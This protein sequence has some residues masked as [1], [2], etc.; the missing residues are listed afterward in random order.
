VREKRIRYEQTGETLTFRLPAEYGRYWMQPTAVL[1]LM[2][3]VTRA[4]E[5]Y[6]QRYR[7]QCQQAG[8]S[9]VP[10]QAGP[11]KSRPR[12]VVWEVEVP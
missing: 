6:R 4:L 11:R 3:I 7:L 9:R 1:I 8:V 2:W 10:G 5:V 12:E